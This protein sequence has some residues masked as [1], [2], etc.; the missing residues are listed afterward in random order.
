MKGPEESIACLL[1]AV[2]AL[3]Q[4][5]DARLPEVQAWWINAANFWRLAAAGT[6]AERQ[7]SLHTPK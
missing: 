7:P 1:F 6:V 5:A 4:A 3:R 2:A